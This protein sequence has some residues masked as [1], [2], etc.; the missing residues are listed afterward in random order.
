ME[1]LGIDIFI[2]KEAPAKV[3]F[4]VVERSRT[5]IEQLNYVGNALPFLRVSG[6][7]CG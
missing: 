7:A 1:A 5:L 2:V 3:I 6:Y 4:L